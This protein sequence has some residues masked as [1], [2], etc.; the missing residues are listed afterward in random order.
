MPLFR[1]PEEIEAAQRIQRTRTRFRR[2]MLETNAI[3]QAVLGVLEKVQEGK[4]R[5]DHTMEVS[6][7]RR[8]KNSGSCGC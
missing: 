4:L 8:R 2:A 1:R 6:V 3:L 7:N 5:L